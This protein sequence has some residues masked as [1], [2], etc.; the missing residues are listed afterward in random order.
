MKYI[1]ALEY[2]ANIILM[3]LYYLHMFQLNSYFTKKHFRWIK[4]NIIAIL[5]QLALISISTII[6]YT[7]IQCNN[8]LCGILLGILILYNVP[9]KKAKIPLK[10]TNRA[11]R[12]LVTE[13]IIILAII[14]NINYYLILKLGSINI[15]LPI[16]III[17]NLINSPI[18]KIRK[19]KYINQAKKILKKMPNLIIIG[20]TGSYGKTSVKNY[21]YKMLSTKYEVLVTPKNYNTTM[22]VVKTIR[23]NLKP[24]HQIFI[25]EMGATNINDIKEICDIVN[26]SIGII[27]AIGPQ[28]LE[29]FK[30]IDNIVKTKFELA[31][32]VK[33]NNGV[34]L[35][36]Y[37]NEYIANQKIDMK[38]FSYGIENSNLN[39]KASNLKASSK[40]LSFTFENSKNESIDFQ[41]K[42]IGKYNILNLTAAISVSNYLGISSTKLVPVIKKLKNVEHRLELKTTG[43]LNIIDD[44][45]NSNP[46]SSKF[47]IE[48]LGTF[49]GV[50]ILVTPGLVEL[51][52]DEYKYNF[53]LGKYA[54]KYCDYIFLV[55]SHSKS[56]FDGIKSATFDTN[57]VFMVNSPTQAMQKILKLNTNENITV[58]LE[59]DLPDNYR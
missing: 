19:Q 13:T 33:K 12:I 4:E 56:V 54:T 9:K 16:L 29:S 11:K 50:K 36:N 7:K 27:T 53:E 44:S 30:T 42:I 49:E 35:L 39:F 31:D 48:T 46:I 23:E 2:S 6:Y 26:P 22:G 24:I 18:E 32:S 8:I 43:N 15:I 45:Y 28:H 14:N 57:N 21:L 51:G 58:L 20:I 38:Y 40:G 34:M 41:T 52:H 37:D 59:N 3:S 47:A 25:C 10:I 17:V 5:V 55:G 1:I